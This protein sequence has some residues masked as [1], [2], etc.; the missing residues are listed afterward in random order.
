MESLVP[1]DLQIFTTAST[2]MNDSMSQTEHYP[3]SAMCL[4]ELILLKLRENLDK[5]CFILLAPS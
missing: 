4:T 5:N 1:Q 2:G 3:P